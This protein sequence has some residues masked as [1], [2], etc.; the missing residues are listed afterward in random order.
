MRL[1]QRSGRFGARR[2]WGDERLGLSPAAVG[3]AR[4]ALELLPHRGGLGPRLGT[5]QAAGALVLGRGLRAPAG[6][7]RCDRQS[8]RGGSVSRSDEL[9]SLATPMADGVGV[10]AGPCERRELRL[11]SQSLG[12]EPDAEE[13]GLTGPG[14]GQPVAH[15]LVGVR[16]AVL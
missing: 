8:L 16:P 5:T 14:P 4:G 9:P 13:G 12:A 2:A 11:R 10:L 7:V 6:G 3:G 15:G 1:S